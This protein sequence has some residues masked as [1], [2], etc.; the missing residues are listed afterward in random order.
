MFK[1]EDNIPL[2]K[3]AAGA[4]KT[5]TIHKLDVGQSFAL[6]ADHVPAV[7]CIAAVCKRNEKKVFT[8]RKQK[9]G[10]YRCWRTK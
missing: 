9:D 3:S 6:N 4:R 1:I 5:H 8:V 7:R 10:T 2:S